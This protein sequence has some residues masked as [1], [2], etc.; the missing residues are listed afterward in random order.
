MTMARCPGRDLKPLWGSSPKASCDVS[1]TLS[2]SSVLA[3]E[4]GRGGCFIGSRPSAFPSRER[5]A[6]IFCSS[7]TS[8]S[9]RTESVVLRVREHVVEEL[10][11]GD[12]LADEINL[13]APTRIDHQADRKR[14]ISIFREVAN[15]LTFAV[16]NDGEVVFGEVV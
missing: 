3:F 6:V 1:H 8:S 13:L 5:S 11:A 9:K 16:F 14:K 12:T 2:K 7:R 4:L 15:G 10:L